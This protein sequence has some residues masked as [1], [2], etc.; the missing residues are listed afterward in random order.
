MR[1]Y[2][3]VTKFAIGF[4]FFSIAAMALLSFST[5]Y[6]QKTAVTIRS[7]IE[8][9]KIS[10]AWKDALTSRMSAQRLDSMAAIKRELSAEEIKWGTLINSNAFRWNSFRDSLLTPFRGTNIHDTI[11]V[12][13]GFLG[14]DDAFT[15]KYR[16]VC[17]DLTAL[18]RA[19]GSADEA[20]NKE[21]ID[22][23]FSHEYTHLLHKKWAVQ[24]KLQ[25]HSFMDSILWECLYE[26]IGMYRSLSAKWLPVN[27]T[28][29]QLTVQT[30]DRLSLIFVERLIT[31][32]TSSSL[33]DEEKTRLNAGLSRGPVDQ[34]WGAFPVAVW[35]LQEAGGDETKLKAWI[36]RGPQAVIMLAKKYLS[37]NN[38]AKFK[39]TFP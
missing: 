32:K 23:I 28:L 33:T 5:A 24:H 35:L 38:L 11:F 37:G 36:N 39:K 17:L 1:Y 20:V 12:M 19:Y 22:R 31:I 10:D 3:L 13:L 6:G 16:T 7:G 30:V 14:D 21:R 8:Q 25:L 34:K 4:Y 15:Y 29:P 26:G 9:N 2:K 18:H 27:G